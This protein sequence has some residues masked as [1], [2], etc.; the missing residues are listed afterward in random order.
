MIKTIILLIIGIYVILWA[1]PTMD[2]MSFSTYAS[3]HGYK[4]AL[5]R[6]WEGPKTTTIIHSNKKEH[7]NDD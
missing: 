4:S 1:M 5:I 3:K 6:A 7:H 2:G